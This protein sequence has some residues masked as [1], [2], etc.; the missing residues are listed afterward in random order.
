MPRS[1]AN[2]RGF[3]ADSALEGAGFEPSVP[4]EFRAKGSAETRTG[5][6]RK[7]WYLFGDYRCYRRCNPELEHKA[8]MTRAVLKTYV[9]FVVSYGTISRARTS[10]PSSPRFQP[11]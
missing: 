9:R 4:L 5:Q 1:Y 6:Y 10:K 3:V 8:R 2:R 11:N 7:A